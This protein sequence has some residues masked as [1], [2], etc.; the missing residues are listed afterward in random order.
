M[1]VA[2]VAGLAGCVA[3]S[4]HDE[5]AP[6]PPALAAESATFVVTVLEADAT[7]VMSPSPGSSVCVAEPFGV[8][9][10]TATTLAGVSTVYASVHCAERVAGLAFDDSPQTITVVAVHRSN[11]VTVEAPGDGTSHQ[12]DVERIFPEDLRERAFEGYRDRDAAIREL[13]ARY[14]T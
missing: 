2:V 3:C 7:A 1:W 12:P 6:L 4:S 9:P 13:A 5:R 14:A 11:P 8:D 10:V